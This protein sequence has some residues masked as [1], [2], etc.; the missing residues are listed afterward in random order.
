MNPTDA[1]KAASYFHGIIRLSREMGTFLPI[2][3]ILLSITSKTL[4][5]MAKLEIDAIDKIGDKFWIYYDDRA[6]KWPNVSSKKQL[7]KEYGE[8]EKDYCTK[9]GKSHVEKECPE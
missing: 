2:G 7:I 6:K 3:P 5:E 8:S 4:V 1:G 9:C